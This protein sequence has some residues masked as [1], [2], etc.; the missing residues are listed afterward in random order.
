MPVE[1]LNDEVSGELKKRLNHPFLGSFAIALVLYNWPVFLMVFTGDLSAD[2]RIAQIQKYLATLKADDPNHMYVMAPL[3]TAVLF[4]LLYPMINLLSAY[5]SHYIA[6]LEKNFKDL[7]TSKVDRSEDV[8]VRNMAQLA[9]GAL[10][11]LRKNGKN[12]EDLHHN[13]LNPGSTHPT[14]SL[15]LIESIRSLNNLS[16]D[17]LEPMA[18]LQRDQIAGARHLVLEA[19]AKEENLTK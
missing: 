12:M 18:R 3:F 10:T 5:W 19:F 1:N 17:L 13:L 7:L 16:M 8:I 9:Q 11:R 6:L 4:T 2:T 15:H 14:N